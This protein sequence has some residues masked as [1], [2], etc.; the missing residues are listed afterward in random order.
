MGKFSNA[1]LFV[2]EYLSEPI[3]AL[4]KK[5][6]L[7]WLVIGKILMHIGKNLS[8]ARHWQMSVAHSLGNE[9]SSFGKLL[10]VLGMHS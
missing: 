8:K 10:G 2:Y 6:N 1:R 7:H 3:P 9:C 5:K 4:K